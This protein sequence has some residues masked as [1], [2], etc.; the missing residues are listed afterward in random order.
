MLSFARKLNA[1]PGHIRQEDVGQLQSA[2]FTEQNIFDVVAIVAHFNFMNR[3]ADGLGVEPE[4]EA[5]ESYRRH[6]NEVM[7]AQREEALK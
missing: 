3:I 4:P 7:A 5:E 1:A 6:L 2:G